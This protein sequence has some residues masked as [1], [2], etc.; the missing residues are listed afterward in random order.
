[1]NEKL[2]DIVLKKAN[3]F[4][5]DRLIMSYGE[6]MNMYKDGEIIIKPNF[7]R[8]FRWDIEKQTDFNRINITRN[9]YFS[10]IRGRKQ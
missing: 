1:M 9:P 4:R 7:Q 10:N 6:I 8:A 5:T 2:E 3:K